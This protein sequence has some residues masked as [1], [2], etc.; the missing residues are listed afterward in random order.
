MNNLWLRLAEERKHIDH[1]FA[2]TLAVRYIDNSSNIFEVV[3]KMLSVKLANCDIS[4]QEIRNRF[5][6]Y[7]SLLEPILSQDLH[8]YLNRDFA[9]TSCLHVL[10]LHRGFHAL[11][12]FRL[13]NAIWNDKQQADA[14]WIQM[15]LGEVYSMDI[16]P[17]AGIGHPVVI[18]HSFGITIGETTVIGGD[19]F[20]FH[21]VTLGGTGLHGGNRHPKIGSNVLLG[22]GSTVLG[23]ISIG[24]KVLVAAGS[25]IL[26]DVPDDSTVAGNPARRVGRFKKNQIVDL[27]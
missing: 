9:A 22:A 15:R 23:N 13:S 1:T 17:A 16:H 26:K 18:D 25:M 24:S 14:Q 8:A 21:N 7:S 27:I 20:I 4:E 3:C 11:S 6:P 5:E 10:L 19:Y 12:G 2:E